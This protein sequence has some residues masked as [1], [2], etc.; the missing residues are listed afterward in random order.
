MN[1]FYTDEELRTL[2]FKAVGNN[3][4]LSRKASIYGAEKICL[5]NNVR[6]DDFCIL[7]GRIEVGNF[8][9]IAAYTALY[10]AN[11]GIFIKDFSGI[12]SR[13]AVYAESDCYGGECMTNPMVPACYRK[14]Y[15]GPVVLEKHV[16]VG[17]GC[18]I[19]PN[20]TLGLGASVGAMSLV[21]RS[22]EPLSV[23]V[24]IPARKIKGRDT[25]FLKLEK[26]FLAQNEELL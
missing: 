13:C 16:V 2:G 25:T 6:I 26:K 7:S 23:C 19:L 18:T 17:S 4:Y 1:S 21:N 24:G 3:V 15:G 22:I 12:S 8:V 20:V 5:G 14:T 10:G 9:H 11:Q